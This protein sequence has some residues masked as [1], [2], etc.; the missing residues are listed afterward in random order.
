MPVHA[1]IYG[2]YNGEGQPEWIQLLA[3][4]V[5]LYDTTLR[6]G[7]QTEGV[8]FSTEDKLDILKRLDHFGMDYIEGGW[9]GS[10][11]KDAAFFEAASSMRLKHARLTA[12]GSTRRAGIT[13]AEDVNLRTIVASGAECVAIFGKAWDLHVSNALKISNEENLELVADSVA[14][15]K[16]NGREVVFDAEH[17]FDGY[18]HNAP[19]AMEVLEAAASAG[20]DWLVLCDTNGGSLPSF[21]GEAVKAVRQRF[22]VPIG[23]HAHNDGELAVANSLAAVA[24]GATM[25]QGTVNGLGER[26]GNAN[27][28]S[29]IPNLSL[30]M[31]RSITPPDLGLLTSLSNFV[32]ETAN[33]LADPKLPYVGKSAFAHKG[34]VHVSAMMRDPRT[35]EHIDP[36]LVGNQRRMLVSELAG[37]ASIQAK[38]REFGIDTEKEGGRAILEHLKRLEA[39]GYQFEGADASFELLVRRLRDDIKPPFHLEGFRIFVDVSGEN[40]S[41]E[42]SIKVL[43]SS[44]MMEH[45]AANGNGPVNALDRA[46]RKALERFYPQLRE[47]RLADYKVR[48][49]DGKDATG[50]KVRVLIR[51]TDGKE[52]WTT[53]GVSTNI[54]EASLAALLDSMEYKLLKH[55]N[56]G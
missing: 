21:V 30:K 52:T 45:T 53:V 48:V 26:T 13:A 35:Y 32:A 44:G 2:P 43:D 18:A 20:A 41:S 47:V 5:A 38:V 50:A 37:T 42:A 46:V 36:A 12:F 49:I 51:S 23:V 56:G 34:G 39:E 19:Y 1:L 7:S 8:S 3:D 15:L 27:L 28:C 14:F 31:N 40:V 6:D 25:V 54:I 29:I 11:P 10:N 9:P 4:K 17:F 22:D 24:A 55:S 16:S 33:V